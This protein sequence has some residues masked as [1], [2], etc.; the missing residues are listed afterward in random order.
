ML[1]F[2][3]SLSALNAQKLNKL[4]E[5]YSPA[6]LYDRVKSDSALADAVGAAAH[7]RLLDYRSPDCLER[8]L[9][10]VYKCGANIL[11]LADKRYPERLNQAPVC[12]PPV[13]YYKGDITLLDTVCVAVVGTRHSSVYGKE[14]AH[15]LAADMCGYSVT[16]VS[17][18]ATGIDAYAHT[19]ALESGG[20]TIAVLGS[21]LGKPTPASNTALF[22][23]IA[24]C[25]LAVSEYF[26]TV[27]AGKYTFPE[28]NRIIS[29]LSSAVIIVEAAKKSGALITADRAVEQ[30]R[31]LFAVPG[32]VTSPKSEGTNDLLK[33][34]ARPVTC[35]KDVLAF[36]NLQAAKILPANK[37]LA[38]DIYEE[39]IYNLLQN[40]ELSVDAL[41]ESSG[42][43]YKEVLGILFSL[44]MKDAVTRLRNNTYALERRN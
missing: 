24:E 43:S 2:W 30:N 4:L 41:V 11:T 12:P 14:M 26:V 36:L 35:V 18:M 1:Y 21:G 6:E 34:G 32:N 20:K 23:K 31:E 27:D 37:P 40:E 44:E 28:R 9:D 39:K 38:L 33:N 15:R 29:G 17:G 25:G 7:K 22:N 8:M 16:V 5:N 3:L 19:A 13:L 42:F 10:K